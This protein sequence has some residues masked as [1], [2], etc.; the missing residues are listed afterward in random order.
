[1]DYTY[2]HV[3]SGTCF[4]T[5]SAG[6]YPIWMNIIL[7]WD[8]W[9]LI[10][11]FIVCLCLILLYS[12]IENDRDI[13]WAALNTYKILLGISTKYLSRS[14]QHRCIIGSVILV[15]LITNGI[16]TG[17][18]CAHRHFNNYQ[19]YLTSFFYCTQ[20]RL[21]SFLTIPR[22]YK[23][24]DTLQQLKDSG[25]P[26]Y[27]FESF[28]RLLVDPVLESRYHPAMYLDC[29]HGII[30]DNDC[31]ACMMDCLLAELW[32]AKSPQLYKAKENLR[33]WHLTHFVNTNWPLLE[34]YD[35]ENFK[36]IESGLRF[37]WRR[38]VMRDV[39]VSTWSWR[40]KMNPASFNPLQLKT[41]LLPFI[42][43]GGGLT[44]ASIVFV[45]EII[46]KRH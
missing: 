1:M 44:L 16:F 33:P 10:N 7:I 43:L 18:L 24:V 13:V 21:V 30:E 39:H 29:L 45:L 28:K 34:R 25:M 6:Y 32:E 11:L 41:L 37:K 3:K 19:K 46:L 12:K 20:G 31:R 8:C 26:I 40:R 9:I 36:I 2:P 42:I 15:M 22:A 27:G 23:A 38:D 14:V 17:I 5:L 35:L 4:L